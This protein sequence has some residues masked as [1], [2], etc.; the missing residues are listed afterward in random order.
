MLDR[1]RNELQKHQEKNEG[2]IKMIRD[3]LNGY[4]SKLSDLRE[5]LKEAKEKTRLAESLN[6]ENKVLLEDIKVNNVGV[7]L[8][9]P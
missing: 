2:L 5:S 6:G 8:V 4:E 7:L 9:F 3:S 1:V